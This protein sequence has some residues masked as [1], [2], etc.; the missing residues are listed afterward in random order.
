M[1]NYN[2]SLT[3]TEKLEKQLAKKSKFDLKEVQKKQMRDIYTRGQKNYYRNGAVPSDGGTPYDEG[4]LRIS[5][6][7][8]GEAVGYT[9]DY[10][11]HVE[12]GHRTLNGGFVPGQYFFKKNVD[13]QR[14]IYKQDLENKL[15]E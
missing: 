4:E 12:Y 1:A 6:S 10:G 9:K 8:T 14:Q 15:K 13:T 11:P 2:V 5:M 7:Y 3:G